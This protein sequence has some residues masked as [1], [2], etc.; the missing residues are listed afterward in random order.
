METYLGSTVSRFTEQAVISNKHLSAVIGGSNKMEN[1]MDLV[2]NL[3][4]KTGREAIIKSVRESQEINPAIQMAWGYMAGL[5]RA[6]GVPTGEEAQLAEAIETF[7]DLKTHARKVDE[8]AYKRMHT[9]FGEGDAT[10]AWSR[11]QEGYTKLGEGGL[12]TEAADMLGLKGKSF[13]RVMHESFSNKEFTA[14]DNFEAIWKISQRAKK[15]GDF[16]GES[17]DYIAEMNRLVRD[18]FHY[19]T[20]QELLT[21]PSMSR[22]APQPRRMPVGMD[23]L[24]EF[25]ERAMKKITPL[26]AVG[27]LA[28]G[29]VGLRVLN[30]VTGDGTPENP[31]DI[32]TVANQSFEGPRYNNLAAARSMSQSGNF[33]SSGTL[34]TDNTVSHDEALANASKNGIIRNGNNVSVRTDGHNPYKSDMMLYE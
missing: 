22:L 15:A 34:L 27:A 29:I 20:A 6:G 23:K 25:T 30:T 17:N 21:S 32:P 7:M 12:E 9:L 13:L 1:F 24:I 2:G 14:S 18:R 31:Y 5:H 28:A 26:R 16:A 4:G 10:A 33:N 8:G 3:R 19:S 11:I